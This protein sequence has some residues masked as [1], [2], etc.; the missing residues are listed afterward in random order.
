MITYSGIVGYGKATLPSV[1]SWGNNMN[2]LRDP[3][4][5]ITTRRIDKVG[6]TSEITTMI[7]ESGD[8]ACEAINVYAR[9]VNPMVSVSY[10]NNGKNGGQRGNNGKQSF[11]PYRIMNGGAFR[12]PTRDQRDLLP[13]SRQPRLAT[14]SFTLPGF[15]DFSKKLLCQSDNIRN[16]KKDENMIKPSHIPPTGVYKLEKPIIENYKMTSVIQNPLQV[17]VTSGIND[18]ARFNGEMGEVRSIINQTPVRPDINV[19][20]GN[21]RIA[22]N[23]DAQVDTRKYTHEVLS[24]D[25]PTNKS[26]N[27]RVT[28]IQDI[29]GNDGSAF[30]KEIMNISYDVPKLGIEKTDYINTEVPLQRQ[31]QQY[32]TFTNTSQNIYKNVNGEFTREF[33]NNRPNTEL[34]TMNSGNGMQRMDFYDNTQYNL[35][36]RISP[37]GFDPV[38]S[39]PLE[40]FENGVIDMD[41]QKNK[42]R[43]RIYEMQ[44][45]RGGEMPNF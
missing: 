27:I 2:I 14:S 17:S 9:G 40:G 36:D 25:V 13:L 43:Q 20:I 35:K 3:P 10:D 16:V 37:G 30:V 23:V 29:Y 38:P 41:T 45:G 44:M 19:G 32:E 8:R 24:G 39:K 31:L 5:S 34:Y 21:S 26:N 22:K 15:A 18:N 11:L 12:P 1:E 7:D 28:D 4:K 42:M 6:Q 33:K